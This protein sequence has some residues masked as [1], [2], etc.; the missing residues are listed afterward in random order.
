MSRVIF[1][2]RS[3]KL[4]AKLTARLI[5]GKFSKDSKENTEK[6]FDCKIKQ[7]I[8]KEYWESYL[9]LT[10]EKQGKFFKAKHKQIRDIELSNFDIE[11]RTELN[12]IK[13]FVLQ[14][15]EKV[16]PDSITKEWFT[17]TIEN[18]YNQNLADKSIPNEI[19]KFIDYYINER[20]DE[21]TPSSIKKFK[22]VKHKLERFQADK[23]RII[24]I[25]EI[26]ETFKNEFVEYCKKENYAL[27]TIQRDLVFITTFCNYAYEKGLE[28]DRNI[29]KLRIKV[30]RD[31]KHPYLTPEEL[32]IIEKYN[33][34][35][36]LDNVR[37]WLL[38]SCYTGQRVS[39]FMNFKTEMIRQENG[40]YLLEFK[41]QKTNKQMTLPLLPKVVNILNK[42]N[43]CFPKPISDQK[44][45]DYLKILCKQAGINEKMK[46]S[47]KEEIEPETGIYRKREDIYE[48]WELVSSHI[49][50]RS[51]ATNYYGKLPTSYLIYMTGH[52]TEQ[53][54]LQYIGK[55]N[56]D[57]AMEIH[58]Y[59]FE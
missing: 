17:N 9:R 50:R 27:G 28:V 41:Q 44:Y 20:K 23:R 34:N 52:S 32:E 7:E 54:F 40:K 14:N 21:V 24:L 31:I 13:N 8:T 11:V 58:N 47:K 38:I 26:N 10:Q 42:R 37:D 48:K 12:K 56:K 45:N 16:H 51:F 3:Q 35:E 22:V 39:D 4:K 30:K 5:V 53:M 33:F 55:S 1:I 6:I 43:W 25:S 19:L 59:F 46:G 18:Y 15:T 57:L 29:N 49:G 2:Y 36:S